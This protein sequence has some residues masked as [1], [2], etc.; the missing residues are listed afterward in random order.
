MDERVGPGF[1]HN[2]IP[3]FP[4]RE[5]KKEQN[6]VCNQALIQLTFV[7]EMS[8][9]HRPIW[10]Y[11]LRTVPSTTCLRVYPCCSLLLLRYC[12]WFR[13][14]TQIK[15]IASMQLVGNCQHRVIE[16]L[17]DEKSTCTQ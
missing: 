8:L 16:V 13:D 9:L 3:F 15:K 14:K 4:R 7:T 17:Q 2:R 11:F 5:E 10:C 1:L 6:E 12:F